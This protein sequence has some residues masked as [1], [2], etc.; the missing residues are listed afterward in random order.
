MRF[1]SSLISIALLQMLLVSTSLAQRVFVVKVIKPISF[2]DSLF[3]AGG[4]N[5]WNPDDTAF[6]FR[7]VDSITYILAKTDIPTTF[8]CKV[9]RGSWKKVEVSGT[10]TAV[11]NR[12]VDFSKGDTATLNVSG[13]SDYFEASPARST[14]SKNV[15]VWKTDFYMPQFKRTRTIR[16]YLPPDYATSGKR[17]PVV[18]MQDGQNLFDVLTAFSGEWGV[19]ESLDS[20]YKAARVSC[21]VVGIDNG[22][23]FRIEELTPWQNVELKKGGRGDLYAQFVVETLKP[24]IDSAFRTIPESKGTFV[25]GSSL[26]GLISLYIATKYPNVIGGALIFSPSIWFSDSIYS[27][28]NSSRLNPMQRYYFYGGQPESTTMVSDMLKVIEELKQKGVRKKNLVVSVSSDG[29]HNEQYW[30][31]EFPAAI[32]WLLK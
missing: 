14:A 15:S 26:G 2:S 9:T 6:L 28:L 13:W 11:E 4:Q 1:V 25:G 17:Y 20:L 22:G 3:L 19:D 31:R 7:R 29:K 27:W 21:I 23:D 30:K 5:D 16:V 32:S 12:R 24:A 18:Y 10:G 8:E